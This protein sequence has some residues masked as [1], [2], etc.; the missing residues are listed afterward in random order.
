MTERE[1]IM[2][3][4]EGPARVVDALRGMSTD[5]PQVLPDGENILLG[6]YVAASIMGRNLVPQ[7]RLED[8]WAAF[9]NNPNYPSDFQTETLL[10]S[11][12]KDDSRL[13]DEAKAVRE[14]LTDLGIE[15]F[16]FADDG[17]NPQL[18]E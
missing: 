4:R 15:S 17:E 3:T 5:S 6:R 10:I 2:L 12:V 7:N 11:S 16:L 14:M 9:G 8:Y 1:Y 13:D 18:V